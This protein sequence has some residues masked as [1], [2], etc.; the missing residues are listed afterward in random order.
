[1]EWYPLG[2][3]ILER[4]LRFLTMKIKGTVLYFTYFL[5]YIY[6]LSYLVMYLASLVD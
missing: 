5:M 2:F 1:M 4:P 3:K 6:Y